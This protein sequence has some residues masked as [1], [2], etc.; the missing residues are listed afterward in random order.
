MQPT[1]DLDEGGRG[2][3]VNS[4]RLTALPVRIFP[5][6]QSFRM[7]LG[8]LYETIGE[9]RLALDDVVNLK[10]LRRTRKLYPHLVVDWHEALT[11]RL[12]L[13]L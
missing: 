6:P 9:T 5:S 12:E 13:V 7:E 8:G 2:S 3:I 11:E 10:H 1:P 4:S